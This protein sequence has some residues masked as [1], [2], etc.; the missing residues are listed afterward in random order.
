[1]KKQLAVF[2]LLF[3]VALSFTLM[4]CGSK[5]DEA[6]VTEFNSKKTEA[7]KVIA[8]AQNQAK[9]MMDDHKAWMA[10]LDS[11]AKAPKADTTKIAGFKAAITAMDAAGAGMNAMMDS[12][13]AAGNAKTET[14]DQL[15][16]AIAGLDAQLAAFN[17]STK[18]MMDDHK[19]LGADITTF[20][21]GA[22]PATPAPEAAK[23]EAA[24]TAPKKEAKPANNPN[25]KGM[26]QTVHKDATPPNTGVKK[27]S[28]GG[29]NK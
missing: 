27:K 28:A 29:A 8:D 25:M 19:K 4:S 3:A 18:K 24:K 7:D 11:A 15:K 17:S 2:S 13:K 26:D 6:L 1:M 23:P 5:R 22:A 16:A 21:G 9:Q 14:N 12:I 20:L 10:K